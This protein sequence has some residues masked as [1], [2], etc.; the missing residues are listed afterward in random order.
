MVALHDI[1]RY[2]KS[3]E[4]LIHKLP[5]QRL[6]HEITQDLKVSLFLHIQS[7]WGGGGSADVT[8]AQ[9]DLCFQSSAVMALQE[10]SE[11]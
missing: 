6:I 3:M 8:H 4:L 2:Q 11:E 7:G 5:F 10:A 1:H 9:M